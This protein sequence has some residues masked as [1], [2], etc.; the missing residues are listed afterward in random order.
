MSQTQLTMIQFQQKTGEYDFTMQYYYPTSWVEKT[1]DE[2][3][4]KL[5]V[6]RLILPLKLWAKN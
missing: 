2:N 5:F 4:L 3:I 1:S 6:K